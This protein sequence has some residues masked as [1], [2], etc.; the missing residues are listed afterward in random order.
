[1]K[2]MCSRDQIKDEEILNA[3][4][5]YRNYLSELKVY[6]EC[7]KQRSGVS[8]FQLGSLY[9][10]NGLEVKNKKELMPKFEAFASAIEKIK[11]ESP[12][13]NLK[14][15]STQEGRRIVSKA[16]RETRRR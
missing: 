9:K 6:E 16:I 11:Q 7:K 1:M 3:Y 13:A 5:K 2:K 14:D 15:I 12:K 10:Q 4:D 8:I